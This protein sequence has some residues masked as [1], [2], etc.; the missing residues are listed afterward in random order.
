[1]HHDGRAE[2]AFVSITNIG[3]RVARPLLASMFIAGGLDSLQHPE[4]KVKAAARVT[5]PLSERVPALPDDTATVV[6][7][8]GAVQVV[9]GSLLATGIL[10]R[11][12]AFVLAGSLLPTTLAGHPFWE[13]LDEGTRTQQRVHFL[14]NL[15]LLGGLVLAA[16][17]C[18]TGDHGPARWTGR[19]ARTR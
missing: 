19:H 2:E 4:S 7:I 12:S 8:N 9:A 11:L 3:D 15:G 14:K 6:R 17:A 5:G 13:E 1:M 16:T 10:S 18:R